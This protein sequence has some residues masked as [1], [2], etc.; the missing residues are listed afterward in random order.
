MSSTSGYRL[1][2]VFLFVIASILS[3]ALF[4]ETAFCDDYTIGPGTISDTWQLTNIDIGWG[5]VGGISVTGYAGSFAIPVN[6]VRSGN[7]SDPTTWSLSNVVVVYNRAKTMQDILSGD[8][9]VDASQG[10]VSFAWQGLGQGLGPTEQSVSFPIPLLDYSPLVSASVGTTLKYDVT[11]SN[12]VLLDQDVKLNSMTIQAGAQ[13]RLQDPHSLIVD[14]PLG[15]QNYGTVRLVSGSTAFTISTPLYNAGTVAVDG[16]TLAINSGSSTSASYQFS[17]GG[18]LQASLTWQ[19]TNTINGNGTLQASGVVAAGST[20]TFAGSNGA[21]LQIG[22]MSVGGGATL[23]LNV[24]GGGA[25]QLVDGS[26]LYVAGTVLNQGNLT[27][28]GSGTT[29]LISGGVV[30]NAGTIIHSGTLYIGYTTLKN[31]AAAT[32]CPARSIMRGCSSKAGRG[33]P[34]SSRVS[35]TPARSKWTAGRCVWVP[36]VVA[37]VSAAVGT[38]SLRTVA[39]WYSV[40]TAIGLGRGPTRSAATARCRQTV[41]WRRAR[42][43][44]SQGP[45]GPTC[46]S[47][48]CLLGVARL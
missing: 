22:Y 42:P 39:K 36:T 20:A 3:L 2:T 40:A 19:G 33:R 10:S 34:A 18:R 44:R 29:P 48:T 21:N 28:N 12:D 15:V 13:L 16:G 4:V 27:I 6:D 25:A 30:N 35:T 9:W 43:R 14:D 38:M 45:T 46:K 8:T 31:L 24:T 32:A 1:A 37:V 26:N 17:N 5:P 47:V 7:W 23:N 41:L 11:L